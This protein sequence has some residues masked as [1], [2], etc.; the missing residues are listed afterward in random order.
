MTY[1]RLMMTDFDVIRSALHYINS[2]NCMR[3]IVWYINCFA[4]YL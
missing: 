4:Q 2:F 3:V 1:N